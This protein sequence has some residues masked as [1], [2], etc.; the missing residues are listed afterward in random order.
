MNSD[1]AA[2]WSIPLWQIFSICMLII[3]I[4]LV[5]L[6]FRSLRV[7]KEKRHEMLEQLHKEGEVEV[8]RSELGLVDV[9]DA[10]SVS[11]MIHD[12][13]R[14]GIIQ[15]KTRRV[16]RLNRWEEWQVYQLTDP[17]GIELVTE[18]FGSPPG[19]PPE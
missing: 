17:K 13:L 11:L 6:F 16:M 4:L 9:L 18:M 3:S 5:G 7:E 10:F 15:G 19:P 12:L 8:M 1:S 2:L 14:E